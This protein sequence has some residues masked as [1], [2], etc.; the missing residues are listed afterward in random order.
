MRH[1]ELLIRGYQSSDRSGVRAIYGEDEFAR[2]VL[3]HKYRQDV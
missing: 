1:L 2:P 3:I